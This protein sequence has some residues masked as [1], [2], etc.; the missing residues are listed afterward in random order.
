MELHLVAVAGDEDA[1]HLGGVEPVGQ[2]RGEEGTGAHAHVDLQPGQVQPLDGHVERAQGA[3]LVHA[4]DRPA[5]GD[6]QADAA[7]AGRLALPGGLQ[8]KHSMGDSRDDAAIVAA[9]ARPPL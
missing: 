9:A 5:A 8:N 4:A 2:A 3:E 6:G 7:L 1:A